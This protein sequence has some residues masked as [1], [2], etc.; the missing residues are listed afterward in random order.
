[1]SFAFM[2]KW[3]YEYKNIITYKSL[4]KWN[5]YSMIINNEM[6]EKINAFIGTAR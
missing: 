4:N 1:M 2:D 6:A 5:T 3:K